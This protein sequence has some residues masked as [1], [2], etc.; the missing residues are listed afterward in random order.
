MDTR[1]PIFSIVLSV[2]AA[3]SQ[4]DWATTAGDPLYVGAL[5]IALMSGLRLLG[6]MTGRSGS[7]GRTTT[8]S[9]MCCSSGLGWM[10][11]CCRRMVLR[12]RMTRLAG[13]ICRRC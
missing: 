2:A 1:T 7:R 3:W 5:N 4:A 9:G 8:V 13:F 12:F 11:G 10:E 6:T